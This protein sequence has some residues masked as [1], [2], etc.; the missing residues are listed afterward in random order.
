MEDNFEQKTKGLTE[1][2][3][4]EIDEEKK[5]LNEK[6]EELE[7]FKNEKLKE[8]ELEKKKLQEEVLLTNWKLAVNGEEVYRIEPL[9]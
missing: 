3:N 2:K 5:K 8:F 6:I 1:E 7:R 9:R 4:N